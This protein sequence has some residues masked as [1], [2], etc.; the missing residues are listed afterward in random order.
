MIIK[1]IKFTGILAII[2]LIPSPAL[3]AGPNLK[4]M[5]STLGV[6]SA[7]QSNTYTNPLPVQIPG[8]GLVESCADPSL[9]Y[10]PEDSYWY[11][12]CM[13]DP[14]NGEDKTGAVLTFI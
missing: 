11:M 14:L 2:L 13:T 12:Y 5:N 8:Y 1:L 10:C 7:A 3:A 4:T 6:M 9:I